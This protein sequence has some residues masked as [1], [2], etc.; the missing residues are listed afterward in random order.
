[1]SG[2]IA[3]APHGSVQ[4]HKKE[5]VEAPSLLFVLQGI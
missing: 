1:M 2:R 5:T 4:N 3:E